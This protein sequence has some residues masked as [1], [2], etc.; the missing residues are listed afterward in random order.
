MD[1]TRMPSSGPWSAKSELTSL[2][3]GECGNHDETGGRDT[4]DESDAGAG[5]DGCAFDGRTRDRRKEW[6]SHQGGRHD[7]ER[8]SSHSGC[9]PERYG[10]ERAES[11]DG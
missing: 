7:R 6:A 1:D 4:F 2:R 11:R 3:K 8:C 5:A 9:K 10:V